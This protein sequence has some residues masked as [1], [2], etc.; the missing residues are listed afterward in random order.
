MNENWGQVKPT[1]NEGIAGSTEVRFGE[2]GFRHDDG[3]DTRS[4]RCAKDGNN[5][6][7]RD[8]GISKE[9]PRL[10]VIISRRLEE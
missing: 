9:R 10:D 8:F 6:L 7:Y 2:R 5:P 3:T 1:S 4:A